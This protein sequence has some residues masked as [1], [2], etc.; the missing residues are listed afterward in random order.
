MEVVAEGVETAETMR[1]LE[2]LGCDVAQGFLFSPALPSEELDEWMRS[3]R[4]SRFTSRA[5]R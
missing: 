3:D 2:A 5:R 4:A 1:S